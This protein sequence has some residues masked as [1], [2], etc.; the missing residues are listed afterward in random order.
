MSPSCVVICHQCI[1]VSAFS[2]LRARPLPPARPHLKLRLSLPASP[3]D[4][5]SPT[6][7]ASSIRNVRGPVFYLFGPGGGL[8]SSDWQMKPDKLSPIAPLLVYRLAYTR[9]KMLCSYLLASH[10]ELEPI[11]WTLFQ[12]TLQHEHELMRDRHLDQ[13]ARLSQLALL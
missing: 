6:L 13:V 7:S 2:L 5:S 3:L 4:P 9:L 10:T 8:S 11:I 12:H 1:R